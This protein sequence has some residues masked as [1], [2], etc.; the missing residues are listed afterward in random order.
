MRAE[1][2]QTGVFTWGVIIVLTCLILYLF[3]RVIWLV[4][5]GL[6]T[7]VGYYCL[8]PVVQALARAGLKHRTAGKV[9]TGLLFVLTVAGVFLL[10]SMAATRAAAW[11][12]VANHYIQGGVT[13]LVKTE[14]ALSSKLPSWKRAP[15]PENSSPELAA[16]AQAETEARLDAEAKQFVADH[17]KGLL[18]QMVYWLPSLLLV[19][20][21]TYFMLQDGNRFKKHLIR[22]VPNAFFE[23][24]LL[25]VDRVDHSLQN[26]LV[27][28]VKL[29]C[30]DTACLG[31]GLKLAGIPYPF[32]LGLVAA[33]LAWVPYIGSV[34]GCVLVTLVAATDFPGQ[35]VVIYGCIVLFICVRLLDDFLFL[36]M[37]VGR[38]L[39]FHPVLSVLMLFLGAAV[40]GP[41]GLLFVLPVLGVVAVVTETLGQILTDERLRARYRHAR[42]L[43]RATAE[44]GEGAAAAKA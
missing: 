26:F 23:K 44:V 17:L 9:V 3:E 19:P 31:L 12:K 42:Q 11:Q 36:P 32:L 28:M 15:A 41:T 43:R 33:V 34:T 16:Q 6:L 1:T 30:L 27:G 18:L 38:S 4:V 21:L 13:F 5:P 7:L 22:G 8:Q 20:Y 24:T 39:R 25:L 37:T 29:T 35:P 40:A 10:G 14:A 2:P